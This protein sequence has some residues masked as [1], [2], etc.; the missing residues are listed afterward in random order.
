[1]L[2]CVSANHQGADFALLE[3]LAALP[4]AT[5]RERI[6]AAGTHGIVVLSTCNRFELYLDA[7][8]ATTVDAVFT[9]LADLSELHEDALRA[10]LRI[11]GEQA[12]PPHLFAVSAGLESVIIGEVEI[13]GQVRRALR[14]ARQARTVTG[15]LERVFRTAAEAAKGVQT[16]TTLAANGRSLV[17]LALDLAASQ[18]P[19]WA[20]ASI[21]LIGTGA[22]AGATLRALESRGAAPVA[23][24]S[25][26]QRAHTLA[27]RYRIHPAS[28]LEDAVAAADLVVTCTT[29]DGYVLSPDLVHRARGGRPLLV[30]DLGMPRNVDPLV[31]RVPGAQL[32][33][34]E[35]IRLH[36]PLH[37]LTTTDLARC[38]V[39][40]AAVEFEGERREAEAAA[41]I[42]M[43][44]SGVHARVEAEIVRTRA[45]AATAVALRQLANAL[46]HE[47]TLRLKQLAREG[48]LDEAR[49][50][51]QLFLAA[52]P[53]PQHT[54]AAS[55]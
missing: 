33:D 43:L 9:T 54:Q 32:L 23:V 8:D 14:S 44:R 31:A 49:A 51:A 12:V 1:M 20:D 28:D 40:R 37:D 22:Y 11:L 26:S 55:R 38:I 35:T 16:H 48:R 25:P 47:P 18:L 27:N 13:A 3:R 19:A 53:A 50:A 39:A 7:P 4:E 17:A 45:D 21:L 41:L 24:Y 34:L 30:I 6:L 46:L 15:A 42:T 29:A 5:V 10:N 36:A 2:V 52:T